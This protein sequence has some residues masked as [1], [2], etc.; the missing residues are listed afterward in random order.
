MADKPFKFGPTGLANGTYVTNLLN[1]PAQA[2]AGIP[3]ADMPATNIGL[4]V[5]HISIVNT[6]AGA[7][8]FRLCLGA[9]GAST[10]ATSV[11]GWDRSV[12]AGSS[13]EWYGQMKL[14]PTDFLVGG[15]SVTGLTIE[16]EGTMFVV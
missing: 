3:A 2:A 8:T 13:Y 11:V 14:L 1:P 15:G 10:A 16:G 9:T 7:L 12:A 6:T 4:L 5:R